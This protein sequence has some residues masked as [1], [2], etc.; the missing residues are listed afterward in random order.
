[1]AEANDGLKISKQ[2]KPAAIIEDNLFGMRQAIFI[3]LNL[4]SRN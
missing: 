4:S 2:K 1:L 3:R